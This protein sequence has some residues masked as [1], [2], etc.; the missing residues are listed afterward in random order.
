[1]MPNYISVE[2]SS[3]PGVLLFP[4]SQLRKDALH[5]VVSLARLE[6]LW[7]RHYV[8]RLD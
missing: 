5:S 6:I 4:N 3:S 7:L 2:Q 8:T 1:M